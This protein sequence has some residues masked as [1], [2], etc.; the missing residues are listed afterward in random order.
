MG[1]ISRWLHRGG[2]GNVKHF[3][4]LPAFPFLP[5]P[6]HCLTAFSELPAAGGAEFVMLLLVKPSTWPSEQSHIPQSGTQALYKA[7]PASCSRCFSHYS[8]V[9]NCI[10]HSPHSRCACMFPPLH[11]C[12]CRSFTLGCPLSPSPPGKCPS[13]FQDL[14]QTVPSS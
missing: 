11:L 13:A 12:G 4:G 3:N 10:P 2:A 8:S 1:P 6:P 5:G 7:D 14:L 9:P